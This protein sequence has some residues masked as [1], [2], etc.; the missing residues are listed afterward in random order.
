M[1]ILFNV[2]LPYH[3]VSLRDLRPSMILRKRMLDVFAPENTLS[4]KAPSLLV[5]LPN[6]FFHLGSLLS[7]PADYLY[8]IP[9]KLSRSIVSHRSSLLRCLISQQAIITV[10]QRVKVRIQSREFSTR[11]LSVHHPEF[12]RRR[13]PPFCVSFASSDGKRLFR[14]ALEDGYM[15]SYFGLAS[16][17]RTQVS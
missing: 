3:Y 6:I 12:Y 7:H 9:G 17:L 16:Q 15:E 2:C 10:E 14:E 8:A 5:N 1:F 11:S 13:L 4:R